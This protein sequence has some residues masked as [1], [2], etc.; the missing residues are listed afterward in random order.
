MPT[1]LNK[2]TLIFFILFILLR[3]EAQIP[4]GF[5]IM[6]DDK[7]VKSLITENNKQTFSLSSD[8]IQEKHLTMMEEVLASKGR[9]LFKKENNVRWEYYSPINYAIIINKR[10]F[11]INN[12]GKTSIFDTE[13]NKL[14]K[15]INNMILMA[16]QGNFVDDPAFKA[17]FYDDDKYYLAI[18]IPQDDMLKNILESIHIYFEKSG[19]T[20]S[21][22]KFIEPAGD[23]TTIFF[24]NRKKNTNINDDQFNISE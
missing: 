24:T 11:M 13:S 6:Q 23:F 15:E 4:D 8:F 7:E 10:Q 1:K 17:S 14:F 21:Q 9:F 16:I 20:V 18:L 19:M 2:I 22:V 3:L 12:D 5:E